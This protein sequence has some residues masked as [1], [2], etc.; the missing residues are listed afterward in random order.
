M[1]HNKMQETTGQIIFGGGMILNT[2]FVADWEAIRLHKQKAIDK[3]NQLEN[4][5]SKPHTYII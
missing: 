3:N 1:H 5:N 2:P 4:K